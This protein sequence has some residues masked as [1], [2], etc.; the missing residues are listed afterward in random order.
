MSSCVIYR[1][2]EY[3]VTKNGNTKHYY[4]TIVN[5][6]LN[7]HVHINNTIKLCKIIVQKSINGDYSRCSKYMVDKVEILLGKNKNWNDM[8]KVLV[9]KHNIY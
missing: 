6:K 4:Y 9:Y 8:H 7:T 3:L 5:T 1:K 2:H